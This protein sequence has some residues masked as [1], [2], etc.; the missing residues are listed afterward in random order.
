M[1]QCNSNTE[2]YGHLTE[3]GWLKFYFF[4]LCDTS[5][6]WPG[7]WYSELFSAE[8]GNIS[9]KSKCLCHFNKS[10]NIVR[11][12]W[13]ILKLLQHKRTDHAVGIKEEDRESKTSLYQ[14]RQTFFC[15]LLK[16]NY[17]NNFSFLKPRVPQHCF[18][19]GTE[20][21]KMAAH[22]KEAVVPKHQVTKT[23]VRSTLYLNKPEKQKCS[24]QKQLLDT[25]I[26]FKP[27]G[28]WLDH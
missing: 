25:N 9:S 17:R 28:T 26:D 4:F 15:S 11:W 14:H 27:P 5:Q 21:K 2:S 16:Q 1:S 6:H 7:F 12:I 8:V 22:R 18:T 10:K 19:G 20:N 3:A 13:Q 23:T 24:Y